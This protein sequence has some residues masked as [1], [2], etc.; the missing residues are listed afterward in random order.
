MTEVKELMTAMEV[1]MAAMPVMEAKAEAAQPT[2]AGYGEEAETLYNATAES[3]QAFA[4]QMQQA[5]SGLQS[6]VDSAE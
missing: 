3:A 6:I 4:A 2:I 5:M 1:I